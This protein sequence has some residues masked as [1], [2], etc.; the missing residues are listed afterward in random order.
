MLSLR[1]VMKAQPFS[2]PIICSQPET[3]RKP[4][5]EEFGS[6]ITTLPL[7]SGF[8]RSDQVFGVGRFF[9]LA[10]SVLRQIAD[11]QASMPT[12]CGG[13]SVSLKAGFSLSSPTGA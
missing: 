11:A 12:Q 8:S 7:N 10:S 6:G 2:S 13:L 9:A 5:P 1:A 4:V 3:A